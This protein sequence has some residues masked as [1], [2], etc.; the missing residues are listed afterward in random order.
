MASATVQY[1]LLPD[2]SL[3]LHQ[4]PRRGNEWW[5]GSNG[6]YACDGEMRVGVRWTGDLASYL[7]VQ[8]PNPHWWLHDSVSGFGPA[9][10][11]SACSRD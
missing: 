8:P 11:H 9:V 5:Q 3:E 4:D 1:T 6:A 7:A 10:P 2:S